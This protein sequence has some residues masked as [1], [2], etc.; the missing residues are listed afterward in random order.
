[1]ALFEPRPAGFAFVIQSQ[2]PTALGGSGNKI[3]AVGISPGVGIGFWS[4]NH[5]YAA[6][7]NTASG[8]CCV[9]GESFL[10][11]LQ[12]RDDVSVSFSYANHTLSFSATNSDTAQSVSGSLAINLSTLGPSVFLG[13]TGATGANTSNQDIS[14]FT[15]ST[16][17][18]VPEP[19][20]WAMMA[21][22]FAGLGF[23]GYRKTRSA[24]A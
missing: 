9:N 14:N 7:F 11:G 6:I 4:F 19:S 24:L 22:G 5:N 20:T 18:V 13:F 3:G 1:M 17:S 16:P 8:G 15:F 12:L 23:L 10:L 21:L 2:G